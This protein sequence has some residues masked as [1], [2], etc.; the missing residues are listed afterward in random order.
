LGEKYALF[1]QAL[2]QYKNLIFH[3]LDDFLL[4]V[5][6]AVSVDIQSSLNILM[7]HDRLDHLDV[8]FVLAKPGTEGVSQV[9]CGEVR[10]EQRL[11]LFS[12]R[13]GSLFLIIICRD[14]V[15]RMIHF[16]RYRYRSTGTCKYE[17][18][19]TIDL[20]RAKAGDL[21]DLIFLEYYNSSEPP[22]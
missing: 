6:G 11:S 9:V 15:D 17:P 5:L 10:K 8:A 1:S 16:G 13:I 12:L 14:V 20:L 2:L 21:L 19:I 18:R 3:V 22:F 4:L 7:A